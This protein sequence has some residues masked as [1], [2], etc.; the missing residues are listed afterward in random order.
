MRTK[1]DRYSLL[2]TNANPDITGL[3]IDHVFHIV[4]LLTDTP[5]IAGKSTFLPRFDA[6]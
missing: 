5:I 6:E 3:P 2:R 1:I 4:P